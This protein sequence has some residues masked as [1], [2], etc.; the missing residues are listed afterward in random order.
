MKMI[1]LTLNPSPP[2]G[3]GLA[4]QCQLPLSTGWRGGWGVRFLRPSGPERIFGVV[5]QERLWRGGL[6]CPAQM[7]GACEI[8]IYDLSGYYLMNGRH[9]V[10][11]GVETGAQRLVLLAGQ[12]KR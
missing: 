4:S 3:E 10:H 6:R 7:C 9:E 2:S 11:I 8:F 12:D 5:G 1:Y